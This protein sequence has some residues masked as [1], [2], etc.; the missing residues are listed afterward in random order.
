M[1][2]LTPE[3]GYAGRF[4]GLA[5]IFNVELPVRVAGQPP[6]V[7]SIFGTFL[8]RKDAGVH[9]RHDRGRRGQRRLC[10][11]RSSARLRRVARLRVRA[12]EQLGPEPGCEQPVQ[13]GVLP[14]PV[15]LQDVF[16]KPS[17][18]RTLSLTMNYGF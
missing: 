15:P 5:D 17:E 14:I 9:A 10:Q 12:K 8:F 7:G 16:V 2:G 3:E 18:L 1:L 11:Q 4:V 6:H 13:Q